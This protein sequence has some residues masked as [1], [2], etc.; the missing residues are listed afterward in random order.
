MT[1]GG[2]GK[3]PISFTTRRD[4]AR[5]VAHALTELPREKIEWRIFRIEG[6][7]KSYLDIVVE[8]EEATGRVHQPS[9][10]TALG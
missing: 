10:C 2:E 3:S 5:F 7:R 6:D 8:W 4:L 9:V 1:I